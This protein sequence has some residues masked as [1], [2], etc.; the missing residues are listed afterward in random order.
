MLQLIL[1]TL[2]G[3]VLNR[4]RGAW[5]RMYI[6]DS[7]VAAR[8]AWAIPTAIILWLGTTPYIQFAENPFRVFLLLLSCWAMWWIGS[9][10]HS[11]MNFQLW[12]DQWD[13]GH[14]PDD[15]EAYSDYILKKIY[16]EAP[17]PLW[18]E[19]DFLSFHITGKAIEG[20]LRM[21]IMVLP[22][23]ILDPL[24]SLALIVSGLLWG[25]LF[26]IGWALSDEKGWE[27]GEL[28]CGGLT[29]LVIGICFYG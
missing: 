10:A 29:F 15:T 14:I 4:A 19:D 1:L 9:G 22:I 27:F 23:I 5:F 18:K 21:T 26:N 17:N 28:L 3:A 6:W 12:K 2:L 16:G 11:V 20:V 13:K 8:F 7:G 24:A 25:L